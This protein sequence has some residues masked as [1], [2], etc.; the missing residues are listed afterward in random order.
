VFLA[1]LEDPPSALLAVS[2]DAG[3]D[4][5]KILKAAL[6]E[7]GGRGGGTARMAQGS[8]PDTSKLNGL[9]AG[10]ES[11]AGFRA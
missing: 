11:A 8:V 7:A 3:I 6:A 9:L 5:G 2:E 4:A 10:L 1:S